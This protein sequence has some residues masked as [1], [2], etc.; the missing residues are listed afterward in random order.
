MDP[1]GK[2]AR[3]LVAS[4]DPPEF[5]WSPDGTWL[6]YAQADEDFN[7][8]I[9]LIPVDGSRPPFNLSRH[10]DNESSPVWSPDGKMIAFTGRRIENE[11]DIYYV[12]LR[13]ED[14]ETT[15]RDRTLE[16]AVEKIKQARKKAAGPTPATRPRTKDDDPKQGRR[17]RDGPA[18]DAGAAEEPPEGRHR[19]RRH[20]RTDPPRL[21]PRRDRDRPVLVA[22]LEEAGVHGD[23]S[24]ASRASTRSSSSTTSSPSR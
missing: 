20:P 14:D 22:R 7:Q 15:A 23:R 3:R 5:D 21:D 6:V 17:D 8:D 24:T 2:D 18:R 12:W 10:P 9:W 13:D 19:L 11:V 1:K 4:W 16:K